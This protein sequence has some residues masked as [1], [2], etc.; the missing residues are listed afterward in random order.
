MIADLTNLASAGQRAAAER[1]AQGLPVVPVAP[2]EVLARLHRF[3]TQG[4]AAAAR[5]VAS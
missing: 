1:A 4:A 2:P 5:P 3:V